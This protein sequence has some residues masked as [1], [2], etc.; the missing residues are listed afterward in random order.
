MCS[1]DGLG[2]STTDRLIMRLISRKS[3][4]IPISVLEHRNV[5]HQLASRYIMA[6]ILLRNLGLGNWMF[7]VASTYGIAR[8]NGAPWRPLIPL[9]PDSPLGIDYFRDKASPLY[10]TPHFPNL[11]IITKSPK[12]VFNVSDESELKRF[13]L[14]ISPWGKYNSLVKTIV[15]STLPNV[16]VD[17]YLQVLAY[18][19]S[20]RDDIRYMF[21]Y[22]DEISLAAIQQI[23]KKVQESLK[24]SYVPALFP[25]L[26]G[27]HVRRGDI[28]DSL[29]DAHGHTPASA[30]YLLKA[31]SYMQTHHSPVLFIVVSNDY[32]YCRQLFQGSNF[33]FADPQPE[34]IDMAVLTMMDY[35]VLT[36]GTFGWWSAY[37]S[38]AKEI[39]YYNNWPKNGS[40]MASGFNHKDYFPP[41]WVA[42]E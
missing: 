29:N 20:Y 22:N 34:Q 8:L 39:L 23:E 26:V 36:V 5:S 31:V 42:L 1:M 38:D 41:I 9:P 14:D 33:A 21:Q 11:G 25:N 35:L 17:D 24:L 3:Q 16:V 4:P 30:D 12:D 19:D 15:N 32:P 27:I 18:F 37:L 13:T 6:K 2:Q 28:L 10:R 40:L 7:L